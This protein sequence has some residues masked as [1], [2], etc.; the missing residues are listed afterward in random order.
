MA[1][2]LT[3]TATSLLCC[4][5]KPREG[6]KKWCFWCSRQASERR[7]KQKKLT[8]RATAKNAAAFGRKAPNAWL[9]PWLS[10]CLTVWEALAHSLDMYWRARRAAADWKNAMLVKGS[11]QYAGGEG[12]TAGFKRS[13]MKICS[14]R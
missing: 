11:R 2:L 8:A 4:E 1:K 14:R 5:W 6:R 12:R 13:M 9:S 3:V 10:I 7:N